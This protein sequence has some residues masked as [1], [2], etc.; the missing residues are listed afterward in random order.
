MLLGLLLY[1]LIT[2]YVFLAPYYL[3]TKKYSHAYSFIDRL[4]GA[5][6]LGI[7]QIILTEVALGFALQLVSLHL[8]LLNI[9][10][11]TGIL[12]F[13]GISR[14]ELLK[15][16]KEAGKSL[17]DFFNLVFRHKILSIILVL[18]VVQVCWWAFQAWLFPPYAYDAMVYHLPKVAH[19]LQINGIEE[20]AT[21]SIWVNM[22][23]FNIELLFLWNVIFLGNDILVN[24]TQIVFALFAVLAIYGIARKVGIGPRN[25]SFAMIFLF[26]PIVIQQA[27]TSYIDLAVSAMFVIAVNFML[28]KDRPKERW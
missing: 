2:T 13:A 27:T 18:S 7:S 23:P 14:E 4:L 12:I 24:G 1:V 28:L 6:V 11:S 22:P 9:V 8:F 17:A 15:Q 16:F 21:G 20:F 25:A 3:L 26:V 19:I 5:F 10:V